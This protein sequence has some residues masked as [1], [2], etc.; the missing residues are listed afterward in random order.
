[1]LDSLLESS[2]LDPLDFPLLDT[3]LES[4]SLD[5]LWNFL[6][7]TLYWSLHHL[8]LSGVF[9]ARLSNRVFISWPCGVSSVWPSTGVF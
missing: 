5:P 7:S 2:S 4:L 6:Y 3:L 9:F 1:L 8:T